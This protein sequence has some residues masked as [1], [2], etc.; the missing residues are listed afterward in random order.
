M[1][2]IP[3]SPDPI[4][5]DFGPDEDQSHSFIVKVWLEEAAE[6]DH[7]PLWRGHVTHVL[8]GQRRYFQDPAGLLA[9]LSQYLT[10]W[11]Q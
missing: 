5:T 8:D 9:F 6:A 4:P 2:D 3:A 1:S 10:G 11:E 7:P